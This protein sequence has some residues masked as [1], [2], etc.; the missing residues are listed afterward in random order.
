MNEEILKKLGYNNIAL[1]MLLKREAQINPDDILMDYKPVNN[2]NV[3]DNQAVEITLENIQQQFTTLINTIKSL[4]NEHN[5]D[6][7]FGKLKRNLLHEAFD[8][9]LK[10]SSLLTE[11]GMSSDN[12]DDFINNDM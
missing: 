10:I 8:V 12:M 11:V 4:P 5:G 6:D 3:P 7:Y 9:G 2:N 1:E